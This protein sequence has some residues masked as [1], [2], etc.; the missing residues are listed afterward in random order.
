MK[1]SSDLSRPVQNQTG[2]LIQQAEVQTA[3]RTRRQYRPPALT[4][5][6]EIRSLTLG[7]SPGTLESGNPGTLRGDT[8]MVSTPPPQ[9]VR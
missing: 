8:S 6:G 5:Y 7:P 3:T 1:T 2:V 9:G 4:C